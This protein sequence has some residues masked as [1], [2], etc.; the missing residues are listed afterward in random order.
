MN[1]LEEF[2]EIVAIEAAKNEATVM[3]IPSGEGIHISLDLLTLVEPP[4]DEEDA[5]DGTRGT[6][7]ITLPPSPR[8][9][10]GPEEQGTLF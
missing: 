4:E 3:L 9:S 8:L 6:G 2:G 7:S 5:M 10:A 1:G